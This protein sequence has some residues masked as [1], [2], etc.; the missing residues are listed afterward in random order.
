MEKSDDDEKARAPRERF[1]DIEPSPV[2]FGGIE[3]IAAPAPPTPEPE[4]S[5]EN[6][7]CLRGPCRYYWEMVT[8]VDAGNAGGTFGGE[9]GLR[10]VTDVAVADDGEVELTYGEGLV[11]M[12]KQ[13]NRVC[14]VN[15]GY[16]TELTGDCV[17]ECSRWD[18][19]DPSDP[20]LAAR[21][22]RRQAWQADNPEH[23]D[24]NLFDDDEEEEEIDE[25]DD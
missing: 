8:H 3:G 1:D 12:P 13:M 14:L 18:P 16:E 10:E 19:E 5:A 17:Y 20:G 6:M 2:G 9:D 25:H 24:A 7:V 15:S 11:Q 21:L 4:V 23:D 22:A